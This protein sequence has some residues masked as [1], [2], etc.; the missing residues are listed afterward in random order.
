M[1]SR[2]RPR[3]LL[4]AIPITWRSRR[5][6]RTKRR[7]AEIAKLKRQLV[8]SE[9]KR[10]RVAGHHA[11]TRQELED[12][13]AQVSEVSDEARRVRDKSAWRRREQLQCSKMFRELNERA[14]SAVATFSVEGVEY[15]L[16][17]DDTSYLAFFTRLVERLEVTSAWWVRFATLSAATFCSRRRPASSAICCASMMISNLTGCYLPSSRSFEASSRG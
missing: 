1:R 17:I 11:T 8:V 4:I 13:L 3:P 9:T 16:E 12:L 15:P 5:T 6:K 10:R 14:C 7:G 2:G